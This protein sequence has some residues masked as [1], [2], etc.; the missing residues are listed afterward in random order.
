[1][2]GTNIVLWLGMIL[3]GIGAALFYVER[4]RPGKLAA[5]LKAITNRK[6]SK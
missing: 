3:I 1:M 4:T 2:T 6:E 5:W